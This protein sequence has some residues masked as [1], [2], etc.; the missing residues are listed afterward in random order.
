MKNGY[1][2]HGRKV[3]PKMV[4]LLKFAAFAISDVKEGP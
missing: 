4:Y 3:Y 1:L 2:S